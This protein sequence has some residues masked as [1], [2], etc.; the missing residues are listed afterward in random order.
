MITFYDDD[1]IT[2]YD[3]DIVLNHFAMGYAQLCDFL[4]F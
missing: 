2:F 1:M 4:S 3:D